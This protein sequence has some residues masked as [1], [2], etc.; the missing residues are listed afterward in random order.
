T[1]NYLNDGTAT[2]GASGGNPGYT[3]LWKPDLQTTT[4]ITD[5]SAGTY[6]LT[7]TDLKGCKGTTNAI[8]AEP[9]TLAINFTAQ[10][11]V[12][13]FAGSDGT[14]TAS[15]TGGTP[16]YNYLWA[17]GGETSATIS[18]L[19]AGTYT[20]TVT[21]NV[22]C[23]ATK[24]VTITQP[25]VLAASTTVTNESCNSLNDGT[26]TAVPSGGTSGY[27]YLWQP[28]ALTSISINNLS[29]GTYTLT[30]TDSKGCTETA[31]AIIAEPAVLAVSFASQAN[32]SCF[33]GNDAL[34][35]ASPSGGTPNYT[36]LWTPGGTTTASKTNL[37]AG[38]YSITITDSKLCT[39]TNSV[40]IT[41]PLAPL[42]V[43]AASLPASCYGSLN[44]SVSSSASDG[45]GPY[46]YTWMPGN[47]SGQNITN[48]A[49]G[50]YTVT[51]TD[52]LGCV[53]T[54]PT[55]VTQPAKI[56]LTATSVNSDCGL[57]N[58]QS[59]VSVSGGNDPYTYLWSPSGGTNA[60]AAGLV[61]GAYTVLVTDSVGC[62]ESQFGNVN[63]NSA[64]VASIFGVTNVTCNGG[65]NGSAH[66]GTSG[67]ISPFTFSW[68]PSGGTDSIATGLTAGTYTVTVTGS[69]GCKSL[70][71]TSPDI[72]QPTPILITVTKTTV[73]CFGGNDGT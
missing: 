43:S 27:T 44:G 56:I 25:A 54:A 30:I 4:T 45:T 42:A 22:G 59:T 73:S 51:A 19:A 9:I 14:V 29:S 67:G 18:N 7:V 21:D 40:T 11:N 49:A 33:A 17:P 16:I 50:T 58:G 5:L 48:L 8:I 12:S 36:Y 26:A 65:T 31:N 1:C 41:Q 15:P 69:N 10:T 13:C 3:Y 70:A 66:V 64:P 53:S 20:V 61:T 47:L 46:T 38:T 39:T 37:T 24:F 55:T 28:G 71:T 68:S 6:T 35:V 52:S 34:V 32:V 2:G 60:T 57:P 72:M 23:T 62:T 63:E